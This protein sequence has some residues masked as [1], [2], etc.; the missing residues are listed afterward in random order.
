MWVLF[1]PDSLRVEKTFLN[2]A[3]AKK[4]QAYENRKRSPHW[5]SPLEIEEFENG[6]LD[7]W[8]MLKML[9]KE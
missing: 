3:E 7:Q 4:W 1:D 2:K 9:R 5:M 8:L 6:K